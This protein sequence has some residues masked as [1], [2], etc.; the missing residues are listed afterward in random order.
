[1]LGKKST[2]AH[3]EHTGV[4]AEGAKSGNPKSPFPCGILV[5]PNLANRFN[6]LS[7]IFDEIAFICVTLIIKLVIICHQKHA[8]QIILQ[9]M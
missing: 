9:S 8:F 2:A 3:G 4:R 7:L 1:L 6:F 5:D